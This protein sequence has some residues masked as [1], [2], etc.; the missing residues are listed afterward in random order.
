MTMGDRVAV[1]RAGTL[2]QCD[3]PQQLYDQPANLF[4]AAFIGSPAMNLYDARLTPDGS[5]LALGSQQ[6]SL[7]GQVAVARPGLADYRGR[8]V[9]AGIRPEHLTAAPP[10]A[11]PDGAILHGEVDLVEALGSELLAHFRIDAPRVHAEEAEHPRGP[12]GLADDGEIAQ[13][14]LAD[15]VARLDPRTA[16]KPGDR[17]PFALD[18]TQIHFF[19]PGGA[20]I[21]H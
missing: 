7:P 20:A 18:A 21:W 4:V 5:A 16:V 1:L 15:G 10:A 3:T 19:D 14:A 9:V 11:A 8:Q 2:Q 12:E 17:F 13:A 6:I